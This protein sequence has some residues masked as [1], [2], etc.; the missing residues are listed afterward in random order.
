L[1]IKIHPQFEMNICELVPLI[2]SKTGHKATR[3]GNGYL[4]RCPAH[5][6]QKAS[7]SI[8][9]G[10]KG[11]I[12]KCHAGC[13]VEAIAATLGVK[14]KELF[15]ANGTNG[16]GYPVNSPRMNIVA[17]YPYRD[18]EGKLIFEVCRLDPK[19][20]RQRRPDPTEAGKWIWN[21]E[22][23]ELVPYRLPELLTAVKAGE[24]V[25]I[26]EG[27]KDVAALVA[28]GFAATC[29]AA[30]AGKWRNEFAEYFEG[31]KA[32]CVIADKDAP[33]RKHAAAVAANVRNKAKSVK[34]IELPDMAGQSVKDAHD[35]FAAGGTADQLR[36]IAEAAKE[37]EPPAVPAK[38]DN[39]AD[40]AGKLTPNDWFK[41]KFPGL[42][43]K[44]GEPV[45]L[46]ATNGRAKASDLNE[47]FM[48]ATLGQDANP[49]T[50]TVY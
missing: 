45:S 6:D 7:L 39:A 37:F 33:G 19:D 32:V 9:E 2:E 1:E 18:A 12:L 10:R 22:G 17:P 44:H 21:L 48:A 36:K 3:A 50:P 4:C 31:A 25:F 41:Q 13:T 14:Q 27:E 28:K 47:S 29:N 49:E 42:A 26:A 5:D 20:F 23:V 15:Y 43:E 38:T 16:N 40:Q 24:T 30:G 46:K 35:F 8:G 11:V 34:A